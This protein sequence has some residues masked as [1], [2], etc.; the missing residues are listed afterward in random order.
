VGGHCW[1]KKGSWVI[2][3]DGGKCRCNINGAPTQPSNACN[4][5]VFMKEYFYIK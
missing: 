4:L 5:A 2:F 1:G 3:A